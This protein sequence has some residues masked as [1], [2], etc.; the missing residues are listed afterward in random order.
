MNL[1]LFNIL[2]MYHMC[3]LRGPKAFFRWTPLFKSQDDFDGT[4]PSPGGT[5]ASAT[6]L[7]SAIADL[8]KDFLPVGAQR[9][10]EQRCSSCIL[11]SGSVDVISLAVFSF[12]SF[13]FYIA[14]EYS[15]DSFSLI[16]W[17]LNSF[18]VVM[19]KGCILH[20]RCP[21]SKFP[22]LR[23]VEVTVAMAMRSRFVAMAWW[24]HWWFL[25]GCQVLPKVTMIPTGLWLWI[26]TGS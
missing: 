25:P 21:W 8:L 4:A 16:M 26:I 24:L 6:L 3:P 23:P 15:I 19:T 13:N 17:N 9:C 14:I 18:G 11:L 22:V 2:M 5:V 10:P 20:L 12:I 7:N 1:I